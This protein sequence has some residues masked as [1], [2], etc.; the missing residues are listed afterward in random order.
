MDLIF[1]DYIGNQLEIYV[2][3]MVV[4]LETEGGHVG[5]LSSI[6]GVL[7]KHQLKLN[8][9]KCSFDVRVDKFLAFMLTRRGIEANLEKCIT[10]I[11][12]RSPRIVKKSAEKSALIFQL[13]RKAK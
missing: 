4:K 9:D 11:N 12:L 7:R 10:V 1:K 2:D 3:D 6:F 13:P 8:L 5:S